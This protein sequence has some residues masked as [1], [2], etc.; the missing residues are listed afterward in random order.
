MTDKTMGSKCG[1]FTYSLEYVSGP[2]SNVNFPGGADLSSY[3]ISGSSI[4]RD[5]ADLAWV[6]THV[7]RL[8]CTNGN[9]NNALTK[10][11]GVNGLFKSVFSNAITLEIVDPCTSSH[12]N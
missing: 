6:G 5:T 12:V 9:T 8:K 2:V 4:T 10:N 11:R 3:A 1:G 7:L